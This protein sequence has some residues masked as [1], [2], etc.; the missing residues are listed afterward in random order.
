MLCCACYMVLKLPST[1]AAWNLYIHPGRSLQ[2]H[3]HVALTNLP[4]EAQTWNSNSTRNPLWFYEKDGGQ[5]ILFCLVDVL[6]LSLFSCVDHVQFLRPFKA[7]SCTASNRIPLLVCQGF[8][9]HA[10]I[11]EDPTCC[12]NHPAVWAKSSILT[13]SR[14]Y[15]W[16]RRWKKQKGFFLICTH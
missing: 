3:H 12:A 13:L 1:P 16:P 14:H 4:R 11:Q 15:W 9:T 8:M 5:E 7:S 6:S 10:W 2:N